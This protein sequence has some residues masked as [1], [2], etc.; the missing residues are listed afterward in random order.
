MPVKDDR[1]LVW[2][3]RSAAVSL[4]RAL[5]DHR[6]AAG[7]RL[8]ALRE[9]RG[10]T[11]EDLA[12]AADLSV[13]TISRFENGRHD[14]RRDTLDKLVKALGVSKT[15]LLGKPPTPLGMN[16]SGPD[17]TA[18]ERAILEALDGIVKRLERLERQQ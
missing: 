10:W 3:P 2:T 17:L 6:K 4:L 13:K 11:Q 14:G 18:G 7:L 15:V 9:A 12:H 8:V 16:G 1:S 5:E